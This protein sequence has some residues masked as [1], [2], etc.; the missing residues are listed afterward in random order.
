V[1]DGS[2]RD[3]DNPKAAA[4]LGIEIAD[5]ATGM[6]QAGRLARAA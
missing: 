5:H 6:G 4:V 1:V 3:G 2:L